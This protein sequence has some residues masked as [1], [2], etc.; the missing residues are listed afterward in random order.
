M[1]WIVVG[2]SCW[3]VFV[4]KIVTFPMYCSI[5]L[6]AGLNGGSFGCGEQI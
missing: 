3:L 1:A 4:G 5:G 2:F 6:V